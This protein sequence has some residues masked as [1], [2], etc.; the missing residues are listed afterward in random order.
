MSARS[1]VQSEDVL[2][3]ERAAVLAESLPVLN[4]LL[5]LL[6]NLQYH[7]SGDGMRCQPQISQTSE[8]GGEELVNQANKRWSGKEKTIRTICCVVEELIQ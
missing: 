1:F 4:H 2:L 7:K 3:A 8:V 5:A 6:L